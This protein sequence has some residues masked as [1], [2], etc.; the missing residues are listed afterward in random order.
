M[1]ERFEVSRDRESDEGYLHLDDREGW[2]RYGVRFDGCVHIISYS[3]RP[4][5]DVYGEQQAH[6]YLHICNLDQF[7][8]DLLEIKR[9][10]IAHFGD[11]YWKEG[12][13]AAD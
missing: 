10:A 6:D 4:F 7:I 12:S 13:N 1:L 11:P 2:W 9:K 5:F 3:E 8:A